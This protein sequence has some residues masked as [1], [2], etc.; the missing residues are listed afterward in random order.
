M[1][2]WFSF[3]GLWICIHI[4][5]SGGSVGI[6]LQV[7]SIST[8]DP[9]SPLFMFQEALVHTRPGLGLN[10]KSI[11]LKHLRCETISWCRF[12]RKKFCSCTLETQCGTRHFNWGQPGGFL[13]KHALDLNSNTNMVI[14]HISTKHSKLV[15]CS[16]ASKF[17]CFPW[18]SLSS[19]YV[20]NYPITFFYI[21]SQVYNIGKRYYGSDFLPPFI[22]F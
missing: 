13:Q 1:A 18:F 8:K 6:D 2:A 14:Q 15:S 7:K 9:T 20:C 16:A 22:C 12:I 17:W 4:S 5:R 10:A 19:A 3:V 21:H 11:Q